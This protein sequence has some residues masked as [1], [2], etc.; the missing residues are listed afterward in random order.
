MAYKTGQERHVTFTWDDST[1][2]LSWK[3][4]GSYR[5]KDIFREMKVTVFYQGGIVTRNVPLKAS[6]KLLLAK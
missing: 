5:G 6:D 1:R 3:V 4:E 2:T